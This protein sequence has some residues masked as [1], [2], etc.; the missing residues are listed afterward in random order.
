MVDQIATDR[1]ATDDGYNPLLYGEMLLKRFPRDSNECKALVT[2]LDQVETLDRERSE[3]V[4]VEHRQRLIGELA[5][6]LRVSNTQLPN[7]NSPLETSLEN[8]N[9]LFDLLPYGGG[10]IDWLNVS[11]TNG[12]I[13][14][15]GWAIRNMFV[16]ARDEA[17]RIGDKNAI[18]FLDGVDEPFE[19]HNTAVGQGATKQSLLV[20]WNGLVIRYGKIQESYPSTGGCYG[21]LGVI[22]CPGLTCLKLGESGM[23]KL[24]HTLTEIL[25]ITIKGCRATRLDACVD[26]PECD[27]T[28]FCRAVERNDVVSSAT[29]TKVHYGRGGKHTGVTAKTQAITLN[30]YEKVVELVNSGD[31]EK[32]QLMIENRWGYLPEK[33]VRVEYQFTLSHLSKMKFSSLEELFEGMGV[34]LEWACNDWFRL[35]EVNSRTNTSRSRLVPAWLRVCNAFAYWAGRFNTRPEAR[36]V[37]PAAPHRM[38]QQAR[39][40]WSSI[41]VRMGFRVSKDRDDALVTPDGRTVIVDDN[42]G[43]DVMAEFLNPRELLK[44]IRKKAAHWDAKRGRSIVQDIEPICC[45]ECGVILRNGL[46]GTEASCHACGSVTGAWPVGSGEV[47]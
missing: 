3:R 18:V 36:A 1:G 27:I 21:S 31:T 20:R 15:E 22:E 30:I 23:C 35:A 6:S 11:I 24:M 17:R 47:A 39:G 41:L 32:M 37:A 16:M 4:Q 43:W 14:N 33:A 44:A 9:R 19:I 42:T 8:D 34:L 46:G 45:D 10:G 7:S 40:L 13:G 26:L 38:C 12:R 29:E 25:G 28:H 5:A 2:R